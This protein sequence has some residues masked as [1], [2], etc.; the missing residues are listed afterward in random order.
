MLVPEGADCV[1]GRDADSAV[2]IDDD[3]VSR[4]HARLACVGGIWRVE[5]LG[6]KNGTWVDGSPADGRP[7]GERAWLSIGGPLVE[8][9]QMSEQAVAADRAR[10]TRRWTTSLHAQ[11][12]LVPSLGR[13][14]LLRRLL[15]SAREVAGAER[16]FVLLQRPSGELEIAATA[17]VA[18][19]EMAAA[20]FRGSVG[21]VERVLTGG[22]PVAVA[23]VQSRVS[24][25]RRPS[26]AGRQIRA[27]VCLPL[28]VDEQRLGV[29]YLDSRQEGA[30]FDEL[31]VEILSA[32][33]SHA[34]LA[35]AVD[36]LQAELRRLAAAGATSPGAGGGA[37]TLDRGPAWSEV[38]ARHRPQEAPR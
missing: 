38:R 6:S 13:A 37:G 29:L 33:A 34:A 16:G 21:A 10:A 22:V 32:L 3:R 15:R 25:A 12:G 7:L 30:S 18:P 26:I 2:P 1:L 11:R 31:D 28:E 8:F 27:L 17:G 4:R 9:R 14:E 36:S 20:E 35:V 23:D 5:D 24:L 19:D